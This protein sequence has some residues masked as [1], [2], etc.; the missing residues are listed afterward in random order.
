[1][2][3]YTG[4]AQV[5]DEF[6]DNTPYELWAEKIEAFIEQYGITKKKGEVSSAQ[7]EEKNLVLDLACGTGTL[8][9]LLVQKGYDMIGVDLSYDMLEIARE[10][11]EETQSDIMYICQDMRD[12][13]LYSTVGTVIC[14]CDS[15]NYVLE[16]SGVLETFQR[17]NNY[18]HPGGIFI[19]DFNTSYKYATVL[20]DCVIAENREDCSFIWE[21]YY[22]ED[23]QIN[24]YDITIFAQIDDD[25]FERFKETHYQRAYELTQMKEMV[26]KAGLE[27]I[28]A[29]DGDHY[30][31]VTSV[32]QRI[33]VIAREIQKGK[34]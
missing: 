24:E 25:I 2:E 29:F 1:M 12:L 32:S 21:N 18:L 28:V 15:I 17:V 22:H 27:F 23:R 5:Y 10:K 33:L 26:E 8:T 31:E 20:G 9:E 3:S 6:M 16:E 4:F 11:Q 7:E 19:F 34:K 13:E 14:A 30:G